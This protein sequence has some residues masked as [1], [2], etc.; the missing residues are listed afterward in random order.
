MATIFFD[1]GA[2]ILENALAGNT[3]ATGVRYLGLVK[4]QVTDRLSTVNELTDTG[5][6]RQ[7]I[8]FDAPTLINNK[9]T[10][11]NSN[12]ITFGEF[13]AA[14]ENIVGAVLFDAQTG[15]NALC[16]TD[17]TYTSTTEVNKTINFDTDTHRINFTV[18]QAA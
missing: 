18:N 1:A 17:L 8:T 14:G 4:T 13:T 16:Y 10:L 5:Y 9:E 11:Q 7:L 6:S 15:G 12:A 3:M 2:T